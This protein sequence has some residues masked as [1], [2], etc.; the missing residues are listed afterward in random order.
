MSD[1]I[2]HRGPLV[3]PVPLGQT[4]YRAV[5]TTA[6]AEDREAVKL[7]KIFSFVN[8]ILWLKFL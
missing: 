8:Y 6:T 3:T 4:V 7:F 1:Y 5:E 2:C